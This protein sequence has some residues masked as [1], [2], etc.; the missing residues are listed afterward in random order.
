MEQGL[1]ENVAFICR[2]GVLIFRDNA[3]LD[4]IYLTESWLANYMLL[5]CTQITTLLI[6]ALRM[7]M[8]MLVFYVYV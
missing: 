6:N 5:H 8:Q 3:N 2:F 1:W 7:F 4:L